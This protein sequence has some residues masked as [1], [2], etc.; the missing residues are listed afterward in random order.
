MCWVL[1][2][3]YN[4]WVLGVGGG[5]RIGERHGWRGGRG[6]SVACYTE[7][8]FLNCAQQRYLYGIN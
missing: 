5:I 3:L 2:G 7:L 4:R 8:V 6:V 1:F